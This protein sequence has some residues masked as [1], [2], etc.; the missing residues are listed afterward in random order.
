MRTRAINRYAG[1]SSRFVT[2]DHSKACAV[3]NFGVEAYASVMALA[4]AMVGNSSSGIIE[5]ASFKL[6]VVNIGIRQ[7]GR[8]RAKNVI[9]VG[10]SKE[11]I[12]AGITRALRSQFSS[13]AQRHDQSLCNRMCG[14]SHCS[15]PQRG[16]DRCTSVAK[17]LLR[18]FC[19]P[20][21]PTQREVYEVF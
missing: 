11:E 10:N 3:E 8:M 12:V 1:I 14:G 13:L 6:P 2:A 17:A 16:E 4:K 18:S 5:A 21:S 7:A 15:S 19:K 9:D 20:L